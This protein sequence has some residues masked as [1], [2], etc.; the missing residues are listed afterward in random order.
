MY[1]IVILV[2]FKKSLNGFFY[3][4]YNSSK[5]GDIMKK[6]IISKTYLRDVSRYQIKLCM[7][8]DDCYISVKKLIKV[9]IPFIIHGNVTVMDDGYYVLE[10]IPKDENYAMR[11]FLDDNKKPLEYY[12][13]IC[14]HN[15]VMEDSLVPYYDDLYLDITYMDGEIKI[16]DEGEFI[17]A[18]ESK[19]IS[20]EEYNLV[21]KVRDKLLEEIGNGT[22]KYMNRDY[23]EYL[24]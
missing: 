10:V 6:K 18:Y 21:L 16:L 4:C 1:V 22:N 19:D 23:S 13:D 14:E 8:V 3:L 2:G 24:F 11:L 7:D 20:E 15:G 17:E 12:F 9:D 5:C